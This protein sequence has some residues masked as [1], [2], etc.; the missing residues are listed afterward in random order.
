MAI[1][2]FVRQFANTDRDW[3]EASPYRHTQAWLAK[4]SGG[5]HFGIAMKKYPQWQSGNEV[6]FFPVGREIGDEFAA[7]CLHRHHL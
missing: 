2:P 3:F 5:T 7:D 1:F 6:V 4:L